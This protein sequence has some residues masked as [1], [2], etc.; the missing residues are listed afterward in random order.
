MSKEQIT[1][2]LGGHS[3]SGEEYA[4]SGPSTWYLYGAG[5]ILALTGGAKL[6]SACGHVNLLTVVDPVV[7]IQFKY[8]MLAVGAAELA[9]AASC[10]LTRAHRLAGALVAWIATGFSI[11]RLGLWWIGWKKPCG[12]LGNLTDTL[13]ISPHTADILINMLLAYLLIGSYG[14]LLWEWK[15]RIEAGSPSLEPVVMLPQNPTS[16]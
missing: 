2:A 14:L 8:L 13:H 3:I 4:R 11:Y 16:G 10:L 9:V 5:V 15:R 6:W 12:C 7:G 1:I